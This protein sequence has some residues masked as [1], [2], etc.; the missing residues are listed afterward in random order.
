[1]NTPHARSLLCNCLGV[2]LYMFKLWDNYCN[3]T[4]IL[5]VSIKLYYH[6]CTIV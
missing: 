3:K 6:I 1:M 4:T 2:I 5:A